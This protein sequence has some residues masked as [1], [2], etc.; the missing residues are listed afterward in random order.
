[1][2]ETLPIAHPE[3]AAWAAR[4]LL[5]GRLVVLPTD[6][7][8]GVAA[9]PARPE[10]VA[11]L[12][13]TKAR[14]RQRAIPVLLADMSQVERAALPLSMPARKLAEAFWPGPLTLVVPKRDDLPGIV[15]AL[16]TVG[17][18]VPDCDAARSVIRAA[19]GALAVTSA[20]RSGGQSSATVE[21]AVAQLGEAVALYLDGGPCPGGQPST[22][23]EVSAAG[24]KVLRAGPIG[25]EALRAALGQPAD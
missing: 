17:V 7:V 9:H 25:E 23:V 16:D 12:Y 20:N 8:Y 2:S 19:G 14:S 10:A 18:R 13:I 3:A 1:M 11:A 5:G 15:S 24:L 21:D 6:T 4:E 22:V